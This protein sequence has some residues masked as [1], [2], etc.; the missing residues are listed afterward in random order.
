MKETKITP[1]PP[2]EQDI[3]DAVNNKQLA[4]F[5]GAGVSRLGPINCKGWSDL[6]RDLISV[7]FR[8]DIINYKA[9]ETLTQNS[10]H[11]KVITICH[12]LLK[13]KDKEDEFFNEMK[14]ALRED[15]DIKTPNVYDDILKL[16]GPFITTNADTHFDRLF[17][18]P[19]VLYKETDFDPER[20]DRTN[21]YKIHGSLI[22]TDSLVFTVSQ[23]FQRYRNSTF[24]E[25]LEKIFKDYVVLFLGYG[26]AEFELLDFLFGKF[27][28]GIIY[29]CHRIS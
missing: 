10:D 19:N 9:R 16:G 11:K 18:P 21:L 27:D 25:F 23:Y 4:I 12:Y 26:M 3:I 15:E 2:I 8:H 22:D 7:C 5:I 28:D 1:I 13:E 6:A 14:K 29:I 20:I 17:N 24:Q